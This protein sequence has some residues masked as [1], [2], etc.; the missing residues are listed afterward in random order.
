MLPASAPEQNVLFMESYTLT[1]ETGVT[2]EFN[3][4]LILV[5]G[6]LDEVELAF[7]SLREI[8]ECYAWLHLV[9]FVPTFCFYFFCNIQMF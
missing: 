2:S 1:E 4:V 9:L 7:R 8:N 3:R 5:S 6:L